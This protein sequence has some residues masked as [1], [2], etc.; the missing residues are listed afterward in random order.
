MRKLN[1]VLLIVFSIIF[2][3]VCITFKAKTILPPENQIDTFC[4]CKKIE[5]SGDLLKAVDFQSEF[6]Y[7]DEKI[8]CFIKLK[9]VTKE[10]SI[11]WKWYSPKEELFKDTG[12][13][14][15]NQDGEYLEAVT[16]YDELIIEPGKTIP[17]QWIVV[18][19]LNGKLIGKREFQIKN[20]V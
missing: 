16:A 3:K 9:N 5:E 12:E 14:K 20:I 19:F 8:L 1:F 17:G 10:I 18:F 6:I 15:V 2:G 7:E 4:L 13:I 11:M